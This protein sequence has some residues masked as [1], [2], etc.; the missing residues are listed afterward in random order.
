MIKEPLLITTSSYK[1]EWQKLAPDLIS[2]KRTHLYQN[3]FETVDTFG[4]YNL[5][6]Y[7]NLEKGDLN[8]KINGQTFEASG[9]VS[10]FIPA[11]SV[12]HWQIFSKNIE[13]NAFISHQNFSTLYNEVSLF[14]KC[15]S[16]PNSVTEIT[17]WLQANKPDFIFENPNPTQD[18]AQAVKEY[19]DNNFQDAIEITNL[20][21]RFN[22]SASQLSKVFKK[23]Y[24]ISP[25]EYRSKLR[26]FQSMYDLLTQDRE[27]V[28]IAFSSGFNDLSRFNK[29]F[30][31]ITNSTPSKFKFTP[32]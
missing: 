26:V 14:N 27:V 11:F 19:M 31:K 13:W 5:Y 22:L 7:A 6:A 2:L 3:N 29:Q 20:A 32:E 8:I 21:A 23:R 4:N 25:V 9:L 1:S 18:M 10:I 28:D 24:G 16:K 17:K 12:I 15:L 30:K